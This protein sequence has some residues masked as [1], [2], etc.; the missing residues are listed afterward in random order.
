MTSPFPSPDYARHAPLWRMAELRLPPGE[1]AHDAL[2]IERVYRWALVLS[3]EA[4]VAPDLAGA[5]A[6]VHDL[7]FIRKDSPD[8]AA[9]GERSAL[10]AGEILA[11]VG[12]AAE[13]I[14]EIK[15]AVRTSS[16]SRGHV[17]TTNL[18][19][20]LQDADRL[21]AIGAVGVLRTAATGQFMSSAER[22]G[23]FYRRDDPCGDAARE[24]DDRRFVI[25]H[26]RKKLLH[27]AAG[28][29]FKSSIEEAR[30]RHDFMMAFLDR[31]RA[32]SA[33]F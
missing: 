17:A 29:H 24:F 7:E 23:A 2:H 15:E 21:D 1:M 20:L 19:R 5:T 14:D 4:G 28:M 31:L 11:S 3:V 32:E 13:E 33:L 12:Y 22:P 27:L 10:A 25:D 8:R 6:L 9:A 18:G 16:W 30:R 26:F